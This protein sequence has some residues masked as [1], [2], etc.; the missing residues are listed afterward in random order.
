MRNKD[1]VLEEPSTSKGLRANGRVI[2]LNRVVVDVQRSCFKRIRPSFINGNFDVV[3][4]VVF[5]VMEAR[6]K[7]DK[8]DLIR[9]SLG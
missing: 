3:N 5:I 4:R 9:I 7:S 6:Y 2:S 8:A 1:V